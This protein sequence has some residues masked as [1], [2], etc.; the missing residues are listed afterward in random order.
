V[1]APLQP[2]LLEVLDQSSQG[3]TEEATMTT[4]QREKINL[5]SVQRRRSRMICV[6]LIVGCS[7]NFP[8]GPEDVVVV[9]GLRYEGETTLNTQGQALIT[10]SVRNE[11]IEPRSLVTREGCNP[12]PQL[13][14][15]PSR[16]GQPSWDGFRMVD[17]GICSGV[18]LE[19]LLHPGESR[20]FTSLIIQAEVKGDSL[21]SGT[22]YVAASF[23]ANQDT[24]TVAAGEVAL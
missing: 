5:H 16:V 23:I 1:A 9:E 3:L 17:E 15:S 6:G 10:V 8:T 19:L 13:F 24:I 18:A 12:I 14:P 11:T 22:Y 4:V 21:N 2:E 20:E 7:S